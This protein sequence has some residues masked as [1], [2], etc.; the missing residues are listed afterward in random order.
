M[1][2]ETSRILLKRFVVIGVT[3]GWPLWDDIRVHK[4]G[5]RMTYE[6]MRMKYGWHTST[7]EWVHTSTYSYVIRMSLACGFNHES[8]ETRKRSFISCSFLKRKYWNKRLL[9]VC[10]YTK[11]ILLKKFGCRLK[12]KIVR[13]KRYTRRI[14]D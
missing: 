3:Y 2:C 1:E 10:S 4:S 8:S 7:Y 12:R 5:I 9:Q 11:N 13:I 14:C 6:H